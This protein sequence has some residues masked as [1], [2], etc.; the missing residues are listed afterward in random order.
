MRKS[1]I[2]ASLA[3][4]STLSLTG[5]ATPLVYAASLDDQLIASPEAVAKTWDDVLNLMTSLDMSAWSDVEEYNAYADAF[6]Q[7]QAII[8]AGFDAD[9]VAVIDKLIGAVLSGYAASSIDHTDVGKVY[10][11]ASFFLE[12][13]DST[14][15]E[16]QS[17]AAG[18]KLARENQGQPVDT[19]SAEDQTAYLA[20]AEFVN[21]KTGGAVATAFAEIVALDDELDATWEDKTTWEPATYQLAAL[22]ASTELNGDAEITM[23]AGTITMNEIEAAFAAYDELTPYAEAKA[24]QTAYAKDNGKV[25]DYYSFW[26]LEHE[27][28]DLDL[29]D[30]DAVNDY[31]NRMQAVIEALQIPAKP[32]ETPEEPVYH[33]VTLETSVEDVAVIVTGEFAAAADELELVVSVAPVEIADFAKDRSVVYDIVVRNKATSEVVNPKADTKATVTVDLPS[34]FKTNVDTEVHSIA[35]DLNSHAQIEDATVT[36]GKVTFTVEHFSLYALVQEITSVPLTPL[37]P[38]TPIEPEHTEVLT[39]TD[40]ETTLGSESTVKPLNVA[41]PN[42]GIATRSGQADLTTAFVGGVIAAASA[43]IAALAHFVRRKA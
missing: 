26:Q 37:T 4:A 35:D 30:Q 43:V 21:D 16:L 31:Y 9:D 13:D 24:E 19:I 42:T 22:L 32:S 2:A 15:S 29:S 18:A 41:V 34:D 27:L 12:K 5:V 3:L 1:Q 17:V 20:Y 25:G 8:D 28:A 33:T 6:D 11:M 23:S 10:G 40:E 7:N 36:D 39:P 38:A 14:L